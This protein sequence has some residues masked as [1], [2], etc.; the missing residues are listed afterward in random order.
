MKSV[1][2][3]GAFGF[4]GKRLLEM[5]LERGYYVHTISRA[6]RYNLKLKNCT[7]WQADLLD[8]TSY[9]AIFDLVQTSGLIH[10]A[11]ESK[12]GFYWSSPT[13]LDWLSA[14]LRLIKSFSEHGGRRVLISGTSAEY[15]WGGWAYLN[16]FIT[17]TIP[18]SLYGASKNALMRVIEQW[19]PEI[20]LSVAWARI[21]NPF[22]PGEHEARLL[23]RIANRLLAGEEISFDQGAEVRD[24]LYV[25]DVCE[26]LICLYESSING[27]VNIGS[28]TGETILSILSALEDCLGSC[29]R[30]TFDFK[31]TNN[32]RYPFVVADTRRLNY[33]VGW[34][35]RYTL[36]ERLDSACNWWRIQ[37][38]R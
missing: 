6:H 38:T 22:G 20:G 27:P 30:I 37:G 33:D 21:F 31:K 17:P 25:D 7:N 11:W 29:G 10:L 34:T 15:A 5:L 12:H 14:S 4:L 24:F 35:P 36:R 1:L 28:G 9:S 8:S 16:E 13:N 32:V 3:T 2:L 18:D 23:P 26:A 19:A